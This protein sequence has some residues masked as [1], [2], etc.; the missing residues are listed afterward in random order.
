MAGAPLRRAADGRLAGQRL[1][2][3]EAVAA[4]VEQRR[5]VGAQDRLDDRA[6]AGRQPRHLADRAAR[7]VQQPVAQRGLAGDAIVP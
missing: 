4:A 3:G 5:A 1:V 6:E 2:L 7:D